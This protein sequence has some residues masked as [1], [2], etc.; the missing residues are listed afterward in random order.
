MKLVLPQPP[1][2]F[3]NNYGDVCHDFSIRAVSLMR[4]TLPD[5]AVCVNAWDY[6]QVQFAWWSLWRNLVVMYYLLLKI[7][8]ALT[9]TFLIL[10][11]WL[12]S[13]NQ[14]N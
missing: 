13:K 10:L 12:S 11:N 14:T 7:T 3:I 1:S 4:Q 8:F 9:A 6:L 2:E 5:H